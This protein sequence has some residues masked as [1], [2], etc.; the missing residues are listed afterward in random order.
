MV[1]LDPDRDTVDTLSKFFK[2]K[3]MND[4]RWRLF[5]STKSDTLKLALTLGIKYKKEKNNEYTH[6]N[7]IIILD[8]NG[9]IRMHHQ[10]LDKNFSKVVNIIS[11]LHI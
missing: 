3:K 7:L 2:E 5:K 10:G 6:S 1:S 9:V 8:K 4:T 11:D